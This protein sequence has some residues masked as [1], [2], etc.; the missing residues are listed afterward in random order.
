MPKENSSIFSKNTPKNSLV[1]SKLIKL[2]A[3]LPAPTVKQFKA[4]HKQ[5]GSPTRDA[6]LILKYILSYYPT[7][8]SPKLVQEIAFKK[9]FGKVAYDYRRLMKAVS[10]VH[11]DLKRYLVTIE[12]TE[13]D[14][15]S[16]FLL[17]K[18]YTKY[19][20][21]HE[22]QL[23]INKNIQPKKPPNY[24]EAFHQV[25]EWNDFS[26]FTELQDTKQSQIAN[27]QQAMNALD[28]YYLGKKL[29]YVC[30]IAIQKK[31][32]KLKYSVKLEE[33]IMQ[34]CK[35]NQADLPLYHQV[36]FMAWQL[37]KYQNQTTF[38][39]LKTKFI[40]HHS[41]LPRT[42]QLYLLT[43]LM[44]YATY[45]VRT[46]AKNGLEESFSLYKIGIEQ[47]IL[48]NNQIII[49]SHF[50]NL[51]TISSVL[52]QFDWIDKMLVTK[53][54]QPLQSVPISDYNLSMA[55]L[56]FSKKAY[57]TCIG[58]L[59]EVDY[60]QFIP[61]ANARIYQ[62]ACAF[63]LKES[64]H[65]IESHCKSF[66][67]YLRRNTGKYPKI[68]ESDLNFIS[69]VRRLNHVRVNKINIQTH[70]NSFASI[71]FH[72]WLQQKINNLK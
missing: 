39:E 27:I 49:V 62:I 6:F 16:D 3:K 66:E 54:K 38:E 53:L 18:I 7:F 2:L 48:L 12:L 23:I 37:I 15:L 36:Y 34:F 8:D 1:K 9:I 51:I 41:Q 31:L 60:S 25:M 42:D 11:L 14:F 67:N 13:D 5:Q 58:H 72:V 68:V 40:H 47:E 59:I 61:S 44:N 56:N 17:A 20:L 19:D 69:I 50:R 21:P 63:E 43:H 26:F 35:N 4:W 32:Y 10:Q 29:K 33:A 46:K 57:K 71:A 30:E 70:F 55:R 45:L 22:R 28:W 64:P 24:P 52:E 65:I